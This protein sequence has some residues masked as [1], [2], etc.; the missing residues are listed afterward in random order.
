MA[1][2]AAD[3]KNIPQVGR[4]HGQHV[5]SITFGFKVA[6]WRAEIRRHKT[7]L[8]HATEDALIVS[9]GGT[10]GSFQAMEEMDEMCEIKW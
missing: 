9:M 5:R 10:V 3:T 8:I 7:C 1:K 6:G 2:L 4:P